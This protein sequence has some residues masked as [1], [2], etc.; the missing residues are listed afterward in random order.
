M[1]KC[2]NFDFIVQCTVEKL[3]K[4]SCKWPL[5]AFLNEYIKNLKKSGPIFMYVGLIDIYL[6]NYII[7]QNFLNM[8]H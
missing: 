5:I 4:I 1:N 6:Y 8:S 3:P 2:G 7:P